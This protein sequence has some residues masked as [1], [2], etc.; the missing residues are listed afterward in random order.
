MYSHTYSLSILN[1]SSTTASIQ[2]SAR[3]SGDKSCT[4]ETRSRPRRSRE[5]SAQKRKLSDKEKDWTYRGCLLIPRSRSYPD[6][7]GTT[8]QSAAH[9]VART[10]C[11]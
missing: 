5:R 9:T 2:L 11:W 1:I 10:E 7:H 6:C 4:H 8:I 3:I